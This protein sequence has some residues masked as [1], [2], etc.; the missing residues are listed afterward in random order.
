M[1]KG[2]RPLDNARLKELA[3]AYVG[4]Y[5]TTQ[6]K[7]RR[8]LER[9]VRERGWAEEAEPDCAAIAE[10]MAA[11]H[12]VDDAAYAAAKSSSMRR[13]GLGTTRVRSALRADGVATA[14]IED[15]DTAA[16]ED[17]EQVALSFARRKRIGPFALG[18]V[19]EG[20]ERRWIAA[21]LR[22]GHS[23]ALSWRII[24]LSPEDLPD[25]QFIPNKL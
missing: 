3:L 10:R 12:Y 16:A 2:A 24:N 22:A 18:D 14:L 13:R 20:S 6:A 25:P 21:M 5:A 4:R 23:P 8:Y 15:I 19:R 11:F 17:E 1:Q 7:L 9:K